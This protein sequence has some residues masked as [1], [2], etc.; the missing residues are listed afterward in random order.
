M[1]IMEISIIPIG[2]KSASVSQYVAEARVLSASLQFMPFLM[3]SDAL[4]LDPA[5]RL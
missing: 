5:G 4:G 1:P 3:V 2:T